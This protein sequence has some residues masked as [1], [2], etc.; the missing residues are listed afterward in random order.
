MR[1]VQKAI[2][3]IFFVILYNAFIY[4]AAYAFFPMGRA[5]SSSSQG[6]G[7]FWYKINPKKQKAAKKH[8]LK[9]IKNSMLK[10]LSAKKLRKLQEHLK[11][12]AV[13]KPT[14]RNVYNWLV[15]KDYIVNQAS[16]FADVN[17]YVMTKYP[18][19]HY[20][21]TSIGGSSSYKTDINYEIRHNRKAITI[22]KLRHRIALILFYSPSN[23]LSLQEEIQL[24]TVAD[25]YGLTRM[26]VNVNKHPA[27]VKKWQIVRTPTIVLLY[28]RKNNKV[29]H[30]IMLEGLRTQQRI[31]DRILYIYYALIKHNKLY[32]KRG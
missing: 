21:N 23:Q 27:L 29:S 32:D 22:H 1:A 15:V 25:R 8:I 16:K 19:L 24:K 20:F 26:N 10:Q 18:Y 14:V 6:K 7:W 30:Y 12:I 2:F 4:D 17:R 28:R 9:K 3:L 31:S 11:D 13:V 5:Y